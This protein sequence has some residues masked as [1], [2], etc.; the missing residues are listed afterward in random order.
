MRRCQLAVSAGGTTLFE[1]CACGIPTV[2]FSFA[3]N[4]KPGTIGM[5]S[6]DI[7]QYAGDARDTDVTGHILEGLLRLLQ[8]PTLRQE[9]ASRMKRLVDGRGAG[10]IADILCSPLTI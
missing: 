7:M 10:R 8:S 6:R 4:Q 2:C 9:Y 1:L 3:D 5:G